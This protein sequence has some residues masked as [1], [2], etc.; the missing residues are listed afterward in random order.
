MKLSIIGTGYVGL[1][2]G[3]C[4]A[5][6]GF[7]VVCIDR[8]RSKIDRLTSGGIPIWEPGLDALVAR[9]AEAGRLHFTDDLAQGV[10]GTDVV[11]VAVGT[12]PIEG[13]D[14]PD[15]SA[16]EAVFGQLKNVATPE[17]LIVIKSTVPVGTT[18]R[19]QA[20]LEGAGCKAT[21][22]SNPEFL[23][24]GC[25]IQ[26]FMEPDRVV[27]GVTT[28]RDKALFAKLY[29]PL[30]DKGAVLFLTTPQSSEL[31]KYTANSL[32]A[33]R[34]AYIN[35]IADVCEKMG[36]NIRDVAKGIGLDH[37]IGPKFLNA[38]PGVGGSCFP[39]DTQALTALA[40]ESG[41]PATII[42]AAIQSNNIRKQRMVEKVVQAAGGSV[43]G[44]TIGVLGLTFKPN[45]DDMRESP[46]IDIVRGLQAAGGRI[47]AYDP[48]G[49]EQAKAIFEG[50]TFV[51]D[52][53]AAAKDADVLVVITEWSEFAPMDLTRMGQLMKR[54]LVVDLRNIYKRQ[55]M[56]AAG[57]DYVSVGREAVGQDTSEVKDL[58]QIL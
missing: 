25:A 51:A 41:A 35:E 54:K 58:L 23:R 6:L 56:M 10:A 5:E 57:F 9:N 1:V 37:R 12:P 18:A 7:D 42:E 17:Q 24:E 39:K 20:L 38:G 44:L 30:T 28:A 52:S 47:Q 15:L 4:F 45:T 31:I 14:F 3:V 21:V 19:M 50:V 55:D 8:D 43:D 11:F 26:D 46:S 29:Q 16:V 32:L 49:M 34:V 48:E 13:S 22:A 40:R 27:A 53:Y 2:S 33:L 36:A